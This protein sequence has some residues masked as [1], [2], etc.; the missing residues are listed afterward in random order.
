[1]KMKINY[2][3]SMFKRVHLFCIMFLVFSVLATGNWQA[4]KMYGGAHWHGY[5]HCLICIAL[6]AVGH[7]SV[8]RGR[9]MHMCVAEGRREDKSAWGTEFFSKSSKP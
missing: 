5:A 4:G 7:A 9:L 8:G 1:M 3:L 6:R 2:S